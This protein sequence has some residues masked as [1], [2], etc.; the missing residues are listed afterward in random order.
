MTCNFIF[1]VLAYEGGC[2]QSCRM[3]TGI[4]GVVL[5]KEL[6]DEVTKLEDGGNLVVCP[7][8]GACSVTTRSTD[9]HTNHSITA[10]ELITLTLIMIIVGVLPELHRKLEGY[11]S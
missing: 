4:R 9:R 3:P 1:F 7:D 11:S 5:K 6:G 10:P 8:W 2:D